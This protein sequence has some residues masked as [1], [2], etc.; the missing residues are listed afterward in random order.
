MKISSSRTQISYYS[1]TTS[2]N[3]QPCLW[4]K[5]PFSQK[6]H[7]CCNLEI[8]C[9]SKY[10]PAHIHV[11]VSKSH[12]IRGCICNIWTLE[13]FVPPEQTFQD[14]IWNKFYPSRIIGSSF[15]RI[16]RKPRKIITPGSYFLCSSCIYPI[17]S[18]LR[19]E[20]PTEYTDCW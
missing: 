18:Y 7:T 20:L 17:P 16:P 14:F 11:F 1:C 3:P 10:W 9:L 15:L 4:P 19:S 13:I 2:R 5:V 12:R 6:Y 8:V